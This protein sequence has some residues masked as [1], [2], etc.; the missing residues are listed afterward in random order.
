MQHR[1]ER[2]LNENRT[3]MNPFEGSISI[4]MRA[5]KHGIH[6]EQHARRNT[7]N[8]HILRLT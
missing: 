5:E 3:S 7:A 2:K 8:R 6:A 4:D 1:D